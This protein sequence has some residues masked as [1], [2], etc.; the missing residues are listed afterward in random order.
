MDRLLELRTL[1]MV[2]ESGSFV[3]ASRRLRRSPPAVTRII[4]DL[5]ARLGVV[6]IERSSRSSVPTEAGRRLAEQARHLLATY[7]E[8]IE[9]AAGEAVTP[10]GHLRITAPLVFG[11]DILA[12]LVLSFLDEFPLIDIDLNLADRVADLQEENLDLALR[13]GHLTEGS[14]VA[15]KVGEVR[16]VVVAS[17]LYTKKRGLPGHPR[18]IEAHDVIQQHSAFGATVPWTFYE[19]GASLNVRVSPRFSVDQADTAIA[20]ARAGRGLAVAL[21]Y[22]VASDI[23]S[24]HLVRCLGDFEAPPLP[25][26]L[27]FPAS[28]RLVRRVRLFIDFV[29]PRLATSAA[30]APLAG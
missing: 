2:V 21:S 26:H 19:G 25:V 22:Q 14:L 20:A 15:R 9:E 13:I 8:L 1:A 24:G 11:R 28:R 12:P 16:R 29:A 27:V 6:L 10:K 7:E 4:S 5:E 3:E 17:P 18:E 23:A 30:L